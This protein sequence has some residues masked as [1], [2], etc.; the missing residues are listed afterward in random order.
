MARIWNEICT[1][2]FEGC[3]SFDMIQGPM[4]I[5]TVERR[6]IFRITH[7]D[8]LSWILANGLHCRNAQILDPNFVEIGRPE[9]ITLRK[10]RAVNTPP[11][12]TL[13]DYVPFYFTPRSPMLMNIRTG[14][15]GLTKRPMRDIAILFTSHRRLRESGIPFV[16]SDRNSTLATAKFH[17]DEDTALNQLSWPL[18]R[19]SDFKR[20]NARPDKIERYMAESLVYQQ[21]PINALEGIA[22]HTEARKTEVGALVANAGANIQTYLKQGWYC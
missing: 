7:V 5:L 8:N 12:G 1:G 18:W 20:D 4:D 2:C 10:P 13:G 14:W 19:A 16:F 11:G 6:L 17:E 3:D 21:V 15:D 9:I 22:L